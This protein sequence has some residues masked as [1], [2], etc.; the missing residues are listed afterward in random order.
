MIHISGSCFIVEHVGLADC[1]AEPY[2]YFMEF[3]E[4]AAFTKYVHDYLSD[5]EYADLQGFL[6]HNPG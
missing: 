6:L 2:S 5:D 1:T 3:I 4:S